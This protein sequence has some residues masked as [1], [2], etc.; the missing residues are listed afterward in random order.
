MITFLLVIG[1]YFF[2]VFGF[3]HRLREQKEH[4]S[5]KK[6]QKPMDSKASEQKLEPDSTNNKKGSSGNMDWRV[7]RMIS[8]LSS[9][10]NSTLVVSTV[11]ASV[12]LSILAFVIQSIGSRLFDIAMTVGLLFSIFGFFYREV[13]ILGVDVKDFQKLNKHAPSLR[14]KATRTQKGIS[15]L[16]MLL[17]RFLLL[18]P[19]PTW[20]LVRYDFSMSW[21]I[22]TSI[23][24]GAFAALFSIAEQALRY[25]P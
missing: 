17:I 19:I 14:E 16:R 15:F 9:R 3:L 4:V 10:E 25:D 8:E 20:I 22:P 18:M 1:G 7:Q 5:S 12:S 2:G 23:I 24:T 13:T 11:A 6:D 21:L